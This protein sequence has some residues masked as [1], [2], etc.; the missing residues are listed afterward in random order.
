MEP[1]DGE[2]RD[3]VARQPGERIRKGIEALRRTP[4]TAHGAG[5]AHEQ[6]ETRGPGGVLG[7]QHAGRALH[8]PAPQGR[9]ARHQRAAGSRSSLGAAHQVALPAAPPARMRLQRSGARAL[10]LARA[11]RARVHAPAPP[12]A[13]ATHCSRASSQAALLRTRASETAA[14]GPERC[15]RPGPRADERSARAG[16]RGC[17]EAAARSEG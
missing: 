12:Q 17:E 15:C 11:P 1:L 7:G 6:R 10:L 9:V 8:T 3:S 4:L 13:R 5:P 2:P 16:G 14:A